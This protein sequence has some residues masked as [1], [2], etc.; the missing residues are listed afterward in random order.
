MAA[1]HTAEAKELALVDKVELRIALTD[2]DQ[3]FE[4]VL[5]TYLA[6]LLLK[7]ASEHVSVRNK[8]ISICQHINTRT[9]PQNIRLPVTALLKQFKAAETPLIRHFDLLYIQQGVTRL[10]PSEIADLFPLLISGFSKNVAGSASNGSTLLNLLFRSVLGHKFPLKGS[11]EDLALRTDYEVSHDDATDLSFWFGKLLLLRLGYGEAAAGHPGLT[12]DEHSFLM[13][14][15]RPDVWNGAAPTGLNLTEV[16]I[17]VLKCLASGLFTDAERQVPVLF[18]SADPNSRIAEA[19]ED[20]MKRVAPNVLLEDK[21]LVNNLYRYYFGSPSY[22][23]ARAALR[24]KILNLLSRSIL[25]TT[26]PE[27]IIK[28]VQNDM[29]QDAR[30]SGEHSI[31]NREGIKLRSAVIGYL[32]FMVHN[33]IPQHIDAIGRPV[34]NLLQ[35]FVENNTDTSLSAETSSVRGRSFEVIGLLARVNVALVAEPQLGLLRWLFQALTSEPHKDVMVS[36]DEALSAII[37]PLTNSAAIEPQVRELLLKNMHDNSRNMRNVRFA[38]LRFANKCL[39]YHDV[40]ARFIDLLALSG[41]AGPTHEVEEE[42]KK[43]LD[44]YWYRLSSNAD[45]AI[46][47]RTSSAQ[48]EFPKFADMI[49]YAFSEHREETFTDKLLCASTAAYCRQL[50]LLEALSAA[51][52]VVD[53]SADWT[54]KLDLMVINN[55]DARAAVRRYITIGPETEIPSS[56]VDLYWRGVALTGLQSGSIGSSK[57]CAQAALELCSLAS[58]PVLEH[59]ARKALILEPVVSDNDVDIRSA[60]ARA[61]GL[62]TSYAATTDTQIGPAFDCLLFSVKAW[63]EAV[64]AAVNRTHGAITAVSTFVSHRSIHYPDDSLAAELLSTLLPALLKIVQE[65]HQHLLVDGALVAIGQLASFG[66]IST[67]SIAETTPLKKLIEAVAEKA[68]AGSE[69]AIKTLGHMSMIVD[70]QDDE[71]EVALLQESLFKL[72]EV[73]QAET[74]FAVGEAMTCFMCRWNSKAM[75]SELDYDGAPPLTAVRPSF[76]VFLDQILAD[77]GTTKPSLKKVCM[78]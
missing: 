27:L 32:N 68:K 20:L 49:D 11:K 23:P 38:S 75:V 24:I 55:E 4:N 28:L 46:E 22:P 16:K 40:V 52:I 6:P 76:A 64:G 3:K 15:G 33:G 17:T 41:S 8:V 35:N 45:V 5:N 14:Q 21:D 78:T 56:A 31:S 50:L 74:Q 18:A 34:I 60:A 71:L 66:V 72:H 37:Q 39:P 73:R 10:E 48:N 9:K 25:S 7:L 62:L 43:G 1:T 2:T 67:R 58:R 70:G 54:R 51:S 12:N 53:M 13:V 77:S 63:K 57:I 47:L 29:V 59:L 61:F 69:K 36:I 26:F 19:A 65:G 42:A 30:D 44:P